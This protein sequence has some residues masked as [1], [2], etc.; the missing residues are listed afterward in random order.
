MIT[1][2]SPDVVAQ[3]S[4]YVYRLIDPRD[5]QTFYVGKGKENRVFQHVKCAIYCYD[6]ADGIDEEDPNKFKT[7]QSIID[8]GL[9]V[10][11]IIQR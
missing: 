2:F 4:Y 10:I 6:G 7:I 11:H 3:L 9:E 5:G 8:S 1:E